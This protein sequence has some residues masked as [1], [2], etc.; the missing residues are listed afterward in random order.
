MLQQKHF[1]PTIIIIPI[2][3]SSGSLPKNGI[4][5][6]EAIFSAPPVVGGKICDSVWQN[7]EKENNNLP[8]EN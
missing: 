8:S 6:S 1:F 4:L 5:K 2:L 7:G 3:G